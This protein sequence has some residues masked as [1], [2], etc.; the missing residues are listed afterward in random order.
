MQPMQITKIK[1]FLSS[2]EKINAVPETLLYF[3]FQEI[4]YVSS[5]SH[6]IQL[7]YQEYA[8]RICYL[9]DDITYLHEALMTW[10][11]NPTQPLINHKNAFVRVSS[12][13]SLMQSALGNSGYKI[14]DVEL[15]FDFFGA[16]SEHFVIEQ[17]QTLYL[18]TLSIS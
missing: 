9:G 6:S 8:K 14:Y 17:D 16:F 5:V 10:F 11:N 2:M 13:L 12:F 15:P 7:Y 18:L 4:Q 3:Q 1:R